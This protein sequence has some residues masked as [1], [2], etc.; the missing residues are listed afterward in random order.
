MP[1][2]AAVPVRPR[3]LR[4][5]WLVPFV[6]FGALLPIACIDRVPRENVGP[7][8]VTKDAATERSSAPEPPRTQNSG[9]VLVQ[10]RSFAV[11]P[12]ACPFADDSADVLAMAFASLAPDPRHD[13]GQPRELAVVV[14]TALPLHGIDLVVQTCEVTDDFVAL[15]WVDVTFVRGP[16]RITRGQGDPRG[17]SLRIQLPQP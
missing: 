15:S 5:R 16:Q 12:S 9:W 6:A 2:V 7:R 3:C 8:A 1:T 17:P 11:L 10:V 4:Q 13:L 14:P